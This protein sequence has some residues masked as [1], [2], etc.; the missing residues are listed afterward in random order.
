M[1][2][3]TTLMVFGV[4]NPHQLRKNGGSGEIKHPIDTQFLMSGSW[5]D[6]P[7]KAKSK[8]HKKENNKVWSFMTEKIQKNDNSTKPSCSWT[9]RS[10]GSSV[11]DGVDCP[12]L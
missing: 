12:K 10:M 6:S 8:K 1:K 7:L 9:E 3:I 4:T 5:W 2:L 11:S